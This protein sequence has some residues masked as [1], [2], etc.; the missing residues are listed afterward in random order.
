MLEFA[1]RWKIGRFFGPPQIDLYAAC[2]NEIRML[3]FFMNHY[4][5]WVR[6]F[7]IF[8]D[9]S[10]DGSLEFLRRF[11]SVEIRAF[12]RRYEDSM[13][14]SHRH[15]YDS[16]WQES[17]GRADWVIVT[18]IDEHL[19]HPSIL[20]YL[21]LR[22]ITGVTAIPGLGC[23]MICDTFPPKDKLLY[24]SVTHGMPWFMMNKLSLFNPNEIDATN[25]AVGRH[26]AKPTGNVVYPRQ[27][28]LINLHYKYLGLPYLTQR[29]GELKSG[30]RSKDIEKR[31]GYEYFWDK[32]KISSDFLYI[33]KNAI[34]V[35]GVSKQELSTKKWWR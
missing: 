35:M 32:D 6:R 5:P 22:K 15:L 8:D 11:P 7:V 31:W 27:D 33:K 25:Y 28:E 1:A 9:G 16:C 29:L 30:L 34:N 18:N 19:Y 14:E 24:R 23:Q 12:E 10:T 20:S 17:R 26:S 13:V 3:P 21:K 2:W 4:Q